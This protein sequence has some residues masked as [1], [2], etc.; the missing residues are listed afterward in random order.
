MFEICWRFLFFFLPLSW[1]L[2]KP[3]LIGGKYHMTWNLTFCLILRFSNLEIRICIHK[4]ATSQNLH[5]SKPKLNSNISSWVISLEVMMS[6]YV[7]CLEKCILP[8][9]L[10]SSDV[11]SGK[12]LLEE[13][14]DWLGPKILC[15]TSFTFYLGQRLLQ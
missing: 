14:L 2:E 10:L 7:Q 9:S 15:Q 3:L 5:F 12:S 13:F 8:C 11:S 4:N 6:Q 1:P